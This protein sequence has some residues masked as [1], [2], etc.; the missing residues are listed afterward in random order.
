[1]A[2]I[3]YGPEEE[4]KI[5]TI[6]LYLKADG[7]KGQISAH[8]EFHRKNSWSKNPQAPKKG[9]TQGYLWK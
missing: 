9:V 5:M 6:H 8:S 3:K 7:V 1:M 2:Y 4:I